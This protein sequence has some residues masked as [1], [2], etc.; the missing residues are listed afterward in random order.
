MKINFSN[1][2]IGNDPNNSTCNLN[3]GLPSVIIYPSLLS[4][5]ECQKVENYLEWKWWGSG[6]AILNSTHSSYSV[7]LQINNIG[8]L[9]FPYLE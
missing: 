9:F 5:T 3:G 6:N 2:Y 1:W 8:I 7:P 4:D